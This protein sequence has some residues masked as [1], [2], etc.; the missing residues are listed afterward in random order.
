MLNFMNT[1]GGKIVEDLVKAPKKQ[2]SAKERRQLRRF[3]K[4]L[5]DARLR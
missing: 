2:Y 4:K 1:F 5:I 3:S